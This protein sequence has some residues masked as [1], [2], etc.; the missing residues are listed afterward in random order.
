[1]G[2]CFS[3]TLQPANRIASKR[4][5]SREVVLGISEA[6]K[7]FI[8]RQSDVKTQQLCGAFRLFL[9]TNAMNYELPAGYD[10]QW[11]GNG[12][13]RRSK[14]IPALGTPTNYGSL[15]H[16]RACPAR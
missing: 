16:G 4:R 2:F 15:P 9:L 5:T 1:M 13:L 10:Y 12:S 11:S 14:S 8:L 6:T 3:A 7:S